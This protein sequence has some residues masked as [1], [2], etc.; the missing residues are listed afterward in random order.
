MIPPEA[1]E[2]TLFLTSAVSGGRRHS[3]AYGHI[4]PEPASSDL[5]A[6]SSSHLLC[7]SGLPLCLSLI[8][9]PV[10][11]RRA[12]LDTPGPSP[13]LKTPDLITSVEMPVKVTVTGSRD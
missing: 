5:S 1:L 7:V 13:H 8:R 11:A 2:E 12:H 4:A 9:T 3:L 6:L 10:T